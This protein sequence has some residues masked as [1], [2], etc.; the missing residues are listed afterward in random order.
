MRRTAAHRAISGALET[1]WRRRLL[2]DPPLDPE[3]LAADAR[4]STGLDDF[5]TGWRSAFEALLRSLRDE[6]ALNA[7]GRTFASGQISQL[8]RARLRAHELWRRHPEILDR[9]LAP[10]LI[11]LGQARSGTTR[12]QRLLA[13]DPEFLNLRFFESFEPVPPARRPDWRP[14]Q[15]RLVLGLLRFLNPALGE[16]HPVS[17]SAPDEPYGLFGFSFHGAQFEAQWRVPSFARFS[18]GRDRTAVY[19]E[20]KR[21]LQT[22][23]WWRG[24]DPD[25]P[26]LLKAPQFMEDLAPLLD[27]FP[28]T[29][30]IRLHRDPA[31]LVASSASL[32][33]NQM[34]VQSDEADPAW[35][36]R[37]WL[38][39]TAR[40]DEECRRALAVHPQAPQLELDYEAMERDWR[41][42][43]RKVYAFLGRSLTPQVEQRMQTYLDKAEAQGFRRHAYR[44]EDFGLSEAEVCSR[45][46]SVEMSA[47]PH[48]RDTGQ[49][50]GALLR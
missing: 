39:K 32:V 17:P 2:P 50:H 35:I 41:G 33:W 5:G 26:W 4:R 37:E 38:D 13:C 20:F 6:A 42:E 25:R 10:P 49:Q 46:H 30:L 44:L 43:M 9:P 18:Q 47:A 48:L 45:F 29:R 15:A 34:M 22:V 1:G 16:I 3:K 27:A 7:I 12:L 23:G 36:G 40:R 19:A 14:L 11:I 28:G 24:D 21:L 8:L 31:I